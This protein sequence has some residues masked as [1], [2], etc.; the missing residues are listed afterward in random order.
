MPKLMIIDSHAILFKAHFAFGSRPLKNSKG[1]TTSALFGFLKV[2]FQLLKKY[3][4]EYLCFAFDTSRQTFRKE[5]YSEYKAHR[6]ETPQELIEQFPYAHKLASALNAQILAL[7]GFEADDILGSLSLQAVRENPEVE[8]LLITGDRDSFQLI[9][10]RIKVGYTSSKS[11]S[12][13]EEYD[14][15]KVSEKYEGLTPDDLITLKGL[16]GDTSDNIPG[17]SG[18]GEK[19]ALKLVQEFKTLENLYENTQN[20]K[21]KLKERVESSKDMAFLS[22]ELARIK[23]DLDLGITLDDLKFE[24]SSSQELEDLLNELE[25]SSLKKE[26][27]N[28][29][30]TIVNREKHYRLILTEE[31]LDELQ[32]ILKGQK[33][34]AFDTETTGLDPI[35]SQLIGISLSWKEDHA[36]YIPIAHRYLQC[37]RQLSIATIQKSLNPLFSSQDILWIAH[38]LK[39]DLSILGNNGFVMPASVADTLL[40]AHLILPLEKLSLKELAVTQLQEERPHFEDVVDKGENFSVVRLDKALE[41]AAADADNTFC[42]YQKLSPE[43]NK[44]TGIQSL[45]ND[46][47]MPLMPILLAMENQGIQID[48]EQFFEL[49]REM[50]MEAQAVAKKILQ[51]AGEDINLNSTQQLAKVLFE[52]LNIPHGKKTKSGYSTAN[53]VLEDLA[54]HY[55]ICA[56][57]L[58]HRHLQKLLSTYTIPLPK[59]ADK[60]HRIHTTYSQTIAITGRLSSNH[61]NLQNIPVRTKWGNRIRRCFVAAPGSVFVSIDYS[62]I[63]LRVMA[64]MAQDEAMIEAFQSGRDIHRETAAKIFRKTL[65]DVTKEERES[66]KAIN[67]GIIYGISPFGLSRQLGINPKMAEGFIH[68]YFSIYSG[69]K[70]FMDE[71]SEMVLKTGEIRTMYGRL[72]PIPE[73]LSKNKNFQEAGKRV[74]INTRI[75]GSAAEILKRAMIQIDKFIEKSGCKIQMLL[76]VHDE[77]IFEVASD[78]VHQMSAI[79]NLMEGIEKLSVPLICDMEKGKSWGELEAFL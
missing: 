15:Q 45:L 26:V 21:G 35:H 73:A 55:P 20:L 16:M 11:P 39:F 57:I 76:Q 59:Q 22:R 41:Y 8:V 48:P 67:F 10:D 62:Q 72:R 75:Q 14:L 68:T 29:K 13:I 18:V 64:H 44:D 53:D 69:I 33:T 32:F 78:E 6:L 42:L 7:P 43:L 34:I 79:K 24:L 47:E 60:N 19:T 23:R 9:Q 46:I 3:S 58:E 4:P 40:M 77:L 27:P 1:M 71:T 30:P 25:F 65:D 51:E 49:N 54:P 2:F 17:I 66:A 63:E 31:E 70:K 74:A 50:E 52:K 5:M 37:P 12:G 38:N 56:W 61:P 28:L 36:A